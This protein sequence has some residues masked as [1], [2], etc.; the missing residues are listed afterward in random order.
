MP[1]R[2]LHATLVRDLG[3]FRKR[4][5]F[6]VSST[7]VVAIVVSVKTCFGAV[8]EVSKRQLCKHRAWVGNAPPPPPP[9]PVG[10]LKFMG[11]SIKLTANSQ[12]YPADSCQLK[13]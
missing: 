6:R 3:K 4:L 13:I 1:K 7:S 12:I 11:G 5:K 10:G 2:L 8:F 9:S